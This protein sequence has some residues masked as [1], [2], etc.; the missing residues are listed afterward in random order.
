MVVFLLVSLVKVNLVKVKKENPVKVRK[1]VLFSQN[2][3]SVLIWDSEIFVFTDNGFSL[4]SGFTKML[5]L[6]EKPLPVV[7]NFSTLGGRLFCFKVLC[8]W[9]F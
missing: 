2:K 5:C 6:P 9:L 4:I 7:V 8:L 3:F 1:Q